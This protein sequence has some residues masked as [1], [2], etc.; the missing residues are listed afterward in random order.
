MASYGTGTPSNVDHIAG[1]A[2]PGRLNSFSQGSGVGP[3]LYI[4]RVLKYALE[5]FQVLLC[6]SFIIKQTAQ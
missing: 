3:M 4:G 1:G 6:R 5:C 2:G